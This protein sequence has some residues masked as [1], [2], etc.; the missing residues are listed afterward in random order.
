MKI[1]TIAMLSS[2][3]CR[4][5]PKIN[6]RCHGSHHGSEKN[7]NQALLDLHSLGSAH[8][9]SHLCDFLENHSLDEELKLTMKLVTI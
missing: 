4:S 6:P 5:C 2:G 3:T 7:L 9:D 8:T 1:S